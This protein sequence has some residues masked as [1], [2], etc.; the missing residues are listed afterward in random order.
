MSP[1]DLTK[2]LVWPIKKNGTY[3]VYQ[4][5]QYLKMAVH[6]EKKHRKMHFTIKKHSLPTEWTK[7]PLRDLSHV[8]YVQRELTHATL[9]GGV[10]YIT[11]FSAPHKTRFWDG[12]NNSQMIKLVFY[13]LSIPPINTLPTFTISHTID[14]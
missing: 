7:V 5:P 8:R 6:R 13:M 4:Q 10:T 11:L 3:F 1:H 12:L 9:A 14:S 2:A